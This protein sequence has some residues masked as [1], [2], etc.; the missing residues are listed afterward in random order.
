MK[1]KFLWGVATSAFQL[2]GSPY[3][4][5]TSWDVILNSNPDVTNHYKLYRD[6]LNLLKELGVNA[7][8]FSIVRYVTE[9]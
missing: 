6:D 3:A 5:W 1:N 9:T 2:E 7:Y 4:D 8:R